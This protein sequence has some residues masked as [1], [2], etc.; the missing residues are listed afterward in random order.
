MFKKTKISAVQKE[1]H[2]GKHQA[3][4]HDLR[5][6]IPAALP[7]G[8]RCHCAAYGN[9]RTAERTPSS[10]P[11]GSTAGRRGQGPVGLRPP[12]DITLIPGW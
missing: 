7:L 9:K 3:T 8:K 2:A 4:Q 6:P 1:L 11:P 10:A 5:F 12:G